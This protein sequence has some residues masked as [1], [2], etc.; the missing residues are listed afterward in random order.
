MADTAEI[1]PLFRSSA[2]VESTPAH[3]SPTWWNDWLRLPVHRHHVTDHSDHTLWLP[4][5]SGNPS[6][7]PDRSVVSTTTVVDFH[8]RR[9]QRPRRQSEFLNRLGRHQRDHPVRYQRPDRGGEGPYCQARRTSR[10]WP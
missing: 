1:E 8:H 2:T 4:H 7:W 10:R 9:G 5:Y 6:A 3:H